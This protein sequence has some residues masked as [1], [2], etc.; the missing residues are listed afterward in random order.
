MAKTLFQK[1]DHSPSHNFLAVENCDQGVLVLKNGGVRK[2]IAVSGINF[3]LKSEEE[4]ELILRAYQQLLNSIEFPLQIVTQSRRLNI[5][6]Y[7]QTFDTRELQETHGGVKTL[8]GEYKNFL[9]SLVEENS[10]VVKR[11]FIVIPYDITNVKEVSKNLFR[12]FFKKNA[13]EGESTEQMSMPSSH[14]IAALDERVERILSLL[15]QIGLHGE[16]L[17]EQELFELIYSTYNPEFTPSHQPTS[18]YE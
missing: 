12:S 16:P 9:R 14:D 2:I 5:K 18:S 6:P 10:I 11:F 1:P 15:S 3:D 4:Q 13:G 8:I 17:N 7:L